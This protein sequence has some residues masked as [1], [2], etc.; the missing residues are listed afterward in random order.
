MLSSTLFR[1]TVLCVLLFVRLATSRELFSYRAYGDDVELISI[2]D[3]GQSIFVNASFGQ[4]HDYPGSEKS[5]KKKFD[6]QSWTLGQTMLL[7]VDTGSY[8][9]WV[10]GND[11]ECGDPSKRCSQDT[12]K[13]HESTK[14][15]FEKLR[16]D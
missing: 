4:I 2:D 14:P 5:R 12:W 6:D 3:W 7:M 13:L 1:M 11:L 16:Y 9:T 10:A 15:V 8:V